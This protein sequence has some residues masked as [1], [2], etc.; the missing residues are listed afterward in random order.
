MIPANRLKIFAEV[1]LGATILTMGIV[2][3]YELSIGDRTGIQLLLST[4]LLLVFM[5]L[6]W[7]RT[8]ETGIGL[9]MLGVFFLAFIGSRAANQTAWVL[10]GSPILISGLLFL[11]ASKIQS[12]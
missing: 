6:G 12:S 11:G 9:A 5:W 2:S 4:V 10:L 3:V 8:S 7:T 1:L